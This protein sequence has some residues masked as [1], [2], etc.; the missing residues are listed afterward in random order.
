MLVLL[1]R[2]DMVV[3]H[4]L[5]YIFFPVILNQPGAGI[6]AH[7]VRGHICRV[8]ST[9]LCLYG[10]VNNTHIIVDDVVHSNAEDKT[11]DR[12]SF[13]CLPETVQQ[14]RSLENPVLIGDVH[15]HPQSQYSRLS[16]GDVL[17]WGLL[18]SV[19]RV[20]GIYTVSDGAEFFTVKSLSTPLD[21]QVVER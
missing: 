6:M 11:V 14:V 18:S 1:R 20:K 15:S 9:A 17:G 2:R 21:K 3:A 13:S 16:R 19:T 5:L 8:V 4:V 12:I 7:P 10:S